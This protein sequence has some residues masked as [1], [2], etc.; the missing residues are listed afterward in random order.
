[1][2][3]SKNYV[4]LAIKIIRLDLPKGFTTF[5]G[6]KFSRTV[7]VCAV[8]KIGK[9]ILVTSTTQ[10]TDNIIWESTK[11]FYLCFD[12]DDSV[13]GVEVK[14]YVGCTVSDVLAIA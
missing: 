5:L 1:M 14:L 4:Y 13:T 9:Q 12:D 8:V 11:D 2:N 6:F 7:H 10:R 3:P